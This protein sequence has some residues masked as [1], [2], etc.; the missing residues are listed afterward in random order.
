MSDKARLLLRLHFWSSDFDSC[1]Y[2]P[3][4]WQEQ[5]YM[6]AE[7]RMRDLASDLIGAGL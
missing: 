6:Q 2:R 3:V 4:A 7:W 1:R 5:F